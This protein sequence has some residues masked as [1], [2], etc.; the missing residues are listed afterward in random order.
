MARK[1]L[2]CM[3]LLDCRRRRPSQKNPDSDERWR[4]WLGEKKK[5]PCLLRPA[6]ASLQACEDRD[7]TVMAR[8]HGGRPRPT[9]PA[10]PQH[11]GAEILGHGGP[12]SSRALRRPGTGMSCVTVAIQCRTGPEC[13]SLFSVRLA[14]A[15]SAEL[16]GPR[17]W[18]GARCGSGATD[19]E[20]EAG[21]KTITMSLLRID[22]GRPIC[23]HR[24][25]SK[26]RAGRGPFRAMSF[27]PARSGRD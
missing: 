25:D 4:E 6:T 19:R 18:T 7:Q 14:A 3:G 22:L 8:D 11:R 20:A 10:S 5:G 12:S 13:A 21:V 27:N 17:S 23:R 1:A 24:S 26:A 2:A 9:A 15:A 16:I